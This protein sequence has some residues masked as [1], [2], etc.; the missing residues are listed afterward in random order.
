MAWRAAFTSSLV[1]IAGWCSPASAAPEPTGAPAATVAPSARAASPL[2]MKVVVSLP[3]LRSF[4]EQLL[5]TGSTVEVL[6]PP[7]VSE[8]GY[9][10]PPSKLAL[11]DGADLVLAVGQGMEPQV[12]KFLR[13]HPSAGRQEV[14][15]GKI[16]GITGEH[17]CGTPGCTADHD[18]GE[19]G[20]GHDLSS[21]PHVWLSPPMALK[22][23]DTLT[24]RI[25]AEMRARGADKAALDELAMRS[26]SLKAGVRRVDER[27]ERALKNAP[28]R[29][30]ITGHN[31]FG[32]LAHRYG[33]RVFALT[34]L[35]A[36]EPTMSA[37]R[38][39]AKIIREQNLTTVFIEPQLSP[40]AAK[41][42][43]EVSG[44][45]VAVLDPL[46]AGDWFALMESNLR[47]LCDALGGTLPP[48]AAQSGG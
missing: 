42:V 13:S 5:P 45:K 4:V 39:A 14:W 8:H 11:M 36:G 16:A 9:E 33:L 40:D 20:E 7:G 41:R 25:G 26:E 17:T 12:E 15:F 2:S 38:E 22:L 48:E 18:H 35:S 34:G 29:T 6:L 43:A 27:Y 19:A 31:A 37:M 28:R 24:E 30:I 10:L 3:P 44:A 21:D 32:H 47:A 1:L 23:I 46:G